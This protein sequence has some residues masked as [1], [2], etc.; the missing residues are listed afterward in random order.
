VSGGHA[1]ANEKPL[2]WEPVTAVVVLGRAGL[3]LTEITMT[4]LSLEFNAAPIESYMD[5]LVGALWALLFLI[6][7]GAVLTRNQT[8]PL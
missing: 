4:P 3:G 5:I 7:I 8:D 6:V 1:K 2:G